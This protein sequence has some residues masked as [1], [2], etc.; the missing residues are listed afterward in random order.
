MEL[1]S[2]VHAEHKHAA[3]APG[4]KRM[5]GMIYAKQST[6]AQPRVM[7]SPDRKARKKSDTNLFTQHETDMCIS[8][9]SHIQTL[10]CGGM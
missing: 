2:L 1:H 6:V 9:N 7:A 3:T 8:H 5:P 10:Q 4:P